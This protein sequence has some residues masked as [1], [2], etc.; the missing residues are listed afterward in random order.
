MNSKGSGPGEKPDE[1]FLMDER[2]YLPGGVELH[3]RIVDRDGKPEIVLSFLSV[4]TKQEIC[5]DSENLDRE[6]E[7]FCRMY[8]AK[9]HDL[10][11]FCRF[12]IEL[13]KAR[14]EDRCWYRIM[15]TAREEADG[16]ITTRISDTVDPA[17]IRA[18]PHVKF[19]ARKVKALLQQGLIETKGGC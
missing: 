6:I 11:A 13:K 7:D 18:D 2:D 16:T 19:R 17:F 12:Y 5:G 8:V 15:V 10:K 4:T 14:D 3:A 9:Y 1:E